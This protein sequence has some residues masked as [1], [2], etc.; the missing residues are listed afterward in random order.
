MD[1]KTF[2]QILRG[3]IS[4]PI[5]KISLNGE[6]GTGNNTAEYIS[7]RIEDMMCTHACI[8]VE[9]RSTGG[10]IAEAIKIYN[11]LDNAVKRGI[12]VKTFCYGYVAS[13]A[14]VVAQA[15]SPGERHIS[16]ES[17][18]LIHKCIVIDEEMTAE[19][20]MS[21]FD[22]LKTIDDWLVKLYGKKSK[23]LGE[24]GARLLMEE[25]GGRGKWL[26]CNEAM[27]FDLADEV[28]EISKDEVVDNVVMPIVDHSYLVIA[29]IVALYIVNLLFDATD[30]AELLLVTG[31]LCFAIA[32]ILTLKK[33]LKDKQD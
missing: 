7:K 1:N 12:L 25:N 26:D 24:D 32:Q 20:C 27:A 29:I 3:N 6:I 5:L 8:I 16:S 4:G 23:Y 10:L 15:A 14:T 2:T 18:Y 13:A 22:T 11:V 9:I 19:E 31:I 21:M 17:L 33:L 30:F 28:C